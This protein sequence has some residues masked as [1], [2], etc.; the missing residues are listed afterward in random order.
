MLM[1]GTVTCGLSRLIPLL[2][3]QPW[4]SRAASWLPYSVFPLVPSPLPSPGF[5]CSEECFGS[6]PTRRIR[7]GV[8]A[9]FCDGWRDSGPFPEGEHRF[10]VE[11]I[12]NQTWKSSVP[13]LKLL[14]TAQMQD[15][16]SFQDLEGSAFFPI[17]LGQKSLKPI[18]SFTVI[19][20]PYFLKPGDLAFK[21]KVWSYLLLIWLWWLH[22][23][24]FI[25]KE[26]NAI[27]VLAA[28]VF[29]K[30]SQILLSSPIKCNSVNLTEPNP[31]LRTCNPPKLNLWSWWKRFRGFFCVWKGHRDAVLSNPQSL[32]AWQGAHTPLTRA[33]P[34]IYVSEEISPPGTFS[35]I[36]R[37]K[38]LQGKTNLMS[39]HREKGCT[40]GAGPKVV[41]GTSNERVLRTTVSMAHSKCQ[42]CQDLSRSRGYPSRISRCL[43]ISNKCK[44][45]K[46]IFLKLRPS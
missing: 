22:Q 32:S 9:G 44:K 19:W 30:T 27:N 38:G 35:G 23:I 6:K 3:L 24:R 1:D 34:G 28:Q 17:P 16:C 5:S 40:W 18:K 45:P 37:L 21:G 39:W 8:R 43:N 14:T 13:Y 2:Q 26:N 10:Y 25:Y 36:P 12:S 41:Q 15:I 42:I 11:N 29:M 31:Y 7:P 4:F 20:A 33:V 46:E